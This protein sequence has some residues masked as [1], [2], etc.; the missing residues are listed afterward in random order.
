MIPKDIFVYYDRF[1]YS[2]RY[3]YNIK[4]INKWRSLNPEYTVHVYDYNSCKDLI[5]NELSSIFFATFLKIKKNDR[6]VD[7][8][9][10]CML[11]HFG[12]IFIDIC[13]EPLYSIDSFLESDMVVCKAMDED[14]ENKCS[15]KLIACGKHSQY[16]K[17]LLFAFVDASNNEQTVWSDSIWCLSKMLEQIIPFEKISR[18]GVYEIINQNIQVIQ[19]QNCHFFY[20]AAFIY[21]NTRIMNDTQIYFTV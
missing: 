9:K 10:L 4:Y 15:S 21:N 13:L 20:D 7:F 19:Q 6:R 1:D 3:E 8:F 14:I 17:Q 18:W 12:G 16:M 11:Y 5:V 2:D